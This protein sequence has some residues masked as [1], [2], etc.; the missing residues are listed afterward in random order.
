MNRRT[1][2]YHALLAALPSHIQQAATAAFA[3]FLLNPQHPAH[4]HHLKPTR[5]SPHWPRSISVSV[6]IGD[7]AIYVVRQV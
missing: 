3:M 2:A 1:M 4:L 7:R 5:K 6:S